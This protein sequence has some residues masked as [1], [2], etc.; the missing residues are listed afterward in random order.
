VSGDYRK[1]EAFIFRRFNQD[2]VGIDTM[3]TWLDRAIADLD[4]Q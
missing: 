4:K 2:G 3:K 1:V